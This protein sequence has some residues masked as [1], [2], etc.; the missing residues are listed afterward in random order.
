M[1]PKTSQKS[2]FNNFENVGIKHVDISPK[3]I[4]L[5]C[6]WLQKL[7]N[8]TFR[9]WKKFFFILKTNTLENNLSFIHGSALIPN[10]LLDFLRFTKTLCFNGVAVGLGNKS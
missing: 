10:Y 5:Q 2:L 3:I 7:C 1:R 4:S 9:E 6:S 8:E